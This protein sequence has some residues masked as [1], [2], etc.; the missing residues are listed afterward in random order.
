MKKSARCFITAFSVLWFVQ[1]ASSYPADQERLPIQVTAE[2][3]GDCRKPG[4][5]RKQVLF[6][7]K[8]ISGKPVEFVVM[9]CSYEDQWRT[10][11]KE[12]VIDRRHPCDKNVPHLIMLKQGDSY[13][14][15][16]CLEIPSNAPKGSEELRLGFSP[17][18][19][20]NDVRNQEAMPIYWSNLLVISWG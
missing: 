17:S 16:L 5:Y 7:V 14:D 8:N 1:G 11:S 15:V 2:L 18:A 20:V 12:I 4:K 6:K 9:S 10:N 19:D 13:E 3:K